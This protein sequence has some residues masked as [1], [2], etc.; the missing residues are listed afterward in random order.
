M[1]K[2]YSFLFRGN[3]QEYIPLENLHKTA[4]YIARSVGKEVLS[5]ILSIGGEN[6]D[7]N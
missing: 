5:S 3:S 2:N 1:G 7:V 4:Y 6:E